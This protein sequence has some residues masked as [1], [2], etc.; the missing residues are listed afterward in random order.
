MPFSKGN[1]GS[2]FIAILQ[3]KEMYLL[4]ARDAPYFF[5][6]LWLLLQLL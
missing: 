5:L 4:K 1:H 2:I 3:K 6:L